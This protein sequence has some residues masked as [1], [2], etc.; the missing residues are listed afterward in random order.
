MFVS[1]VGAMIVSEYLSFPLLVAAD[2]W[3][4]LVVLG[5]NMF[6]SRGLFFGPSEGLRAG[7][8]E[9]SRNTRVGV[10]LLFANLASVALVGV[11]LIVVERFLPARDFAVYAFA[12]NLTSYMLVFVTASS[13]AVYPFLKRVPSERLAPY[14]GQLNALLVGGLGCLLL[15][16]WAVRLMLTYWY[17]EYSGALA[18]LGVLFVL[19]IPQGK[20]MFLNNSYYQA[21]RCE[22][23]LLFANLSGVAVA[24]LLVGVGF[25]L[26]RSTLVVALGTVLAATWRC[27]ASEFYLK[28]RLGISRHGNV[29]VELA[30]MLAF[31][32]TSS[33]FSAGVGLGVFVGLVGGY[34]FMHRSLLVAL[35]GKLMMARSG[36]ERV[37]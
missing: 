7:L 12:A 17:P 16:Y 26:T 5:A 9:Y 27:Y 23:Q 20:M 37:A 13:Y 2:L 4:K 32:A 31:V 19:V 11:G 30:L 25:W 18:Y 6:K 36:S 34:T 24:A 14:Y 21:L 1:A 28:R 8:I 15:C 22:R 33:Y 29:L 35:A 3:V 10:F